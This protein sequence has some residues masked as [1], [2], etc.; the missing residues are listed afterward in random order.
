MIKSVDEEVSVAAIT[1][2]DEVRKE[3]MLGDESQ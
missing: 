3:W 2:K 1:V